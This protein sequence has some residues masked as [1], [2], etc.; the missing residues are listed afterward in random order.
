M[1]QLFILDK[2]IPEGRASV[3]C[4]KNL[5]V[6]DVSSS[7]KPL[8]TD[9]I[10]GSDFSKHLA[11]ETKTSL[12]NTMH[13]LILGTA[14]NLPAKVVYLY[15]LKKHH[16]GFI[17][18]KNYLNHYFF[19][20]VIFRSMT[21]LIK[22]YEVKKGIYPRNGAVSVSEDDL[23]VGINSSDTRSDSLLQNLYYKTLNAPAKAD[24]FD[25]SETLYQILLSARNKKDIIKSE[26]TKKFNR[27]TVIPSEAPFVSLDNFALITVGCLK[28]L[29]TVTKDKNI[30]IDTVQ[31]NG[32]ISV[33]FST[34]VKPSENSL[35]GEL[36][37]SALS[38]LYKKT[39]YLVSV[40]GYIC[41]L[42]GI[43][44]VFRF[45]TKATLVI[46]IIIKE[47]ET[48]EKYTVSHEPSDEEKAA[49][50]ERSFDFYAAVCG[51]TEN[52]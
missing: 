49:I 39:E 19:E 11:P 45:Q 46:E 52:E 50:F 3:L 41:S 36:V 26:I 29:D 21:E 9:K 8:F 33:T 31:K 18:F 10:I 35:D 51:T 38:Y 4:D 27:Y 16:A 43:S 28:V 42:M 47:Y 12:I 30:E 14:E 15:D 6:A 13:L 2:I 44:A 37:L 20:I 22:D 40:I 23:L 24:S 5:T 32:G 1:E 7:A 17:Q 48:E 25:I 34:K